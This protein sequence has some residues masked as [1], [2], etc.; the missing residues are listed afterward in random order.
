MQRDP[1]LK[2]TVLRSDREDNTATFVHIPG[3][4]VLP[5]EAAAEGREPP[6]GKQQSNKPGLVAA[7][8]FFINSSI[9]SAKPL[10]SRMKKRPSPK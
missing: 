7:S 9:A 3:F 5:P 4:A 2:V 8:Y 6:G 1:I 10:P